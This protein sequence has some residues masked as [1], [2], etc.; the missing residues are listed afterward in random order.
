MGYR[1]IF[2]IHKIIFGMSHRSGFTFIELLVTI[3]IIGIL[4]AVIVSRIDGYR[5]SAQVASAK[6]D[7][8]QL[9]Q[10]VEVFKTAND[11]PLAESSVTCSAMTGTPK[12]C[13][14]RYGVIDNG[15]ASMFKGK[16]NSSVYYPV[17]MNTNSNEFFYYFTTDE[18][19]ERSDSTGFYHT[20]SQ[21]P[22]YLLVVTT[23]TYFN[24]YG[25]NAAALPVWW[26]Q[27]GLAGEG[28]RA[29]L[30]FP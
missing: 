25:V 15:F 13:N 1:Q 4:A 28:V 8:T 20:V 30:S 11:F 21:Y 26:I 17:K 3:T 16:E 5:A 18:I 24:Q 23:N 22:D 12:G 14:V 6:S 7:L 9:G 2:P 10:G 29:N 27:N 19:N